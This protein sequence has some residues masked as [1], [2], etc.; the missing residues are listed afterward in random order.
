MV[1]IYGDL[2]DD[3]EE[4]QY[5][6]LGPK[7]AQFDMVDMDKILVYF[8]MAVTKIIWSR[9][10]KDK[11]KIKLIEDLMDVEEEEQIEEQGFLDEI[12]FSGDKAGGYGD[13]EVQKDENK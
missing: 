11:E 5:L 1:I 3:E 12:V 7:L 9:M 4:Y 6:Q 13:E 8:Q 2:V 10:G